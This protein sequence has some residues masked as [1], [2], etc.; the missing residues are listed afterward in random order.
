MKLSDWSNYQPI[1]LPQDCAALLA[2]G[3]TGAIVGLQ[4]SAS[5]FAQTAALRTGG[6]VVEDCYIEDTPNPVIPSGMLRG[7]V[8]VEDGS[9]F[10]DE[11]SVRAQLD[12]LTSNGLEAGIYS[13]RYM[14]DKYHLDDTFSS[15]PLWLSDYQDQYAYALPAG[16]SMVQYSGSGVIPGLS[17]QIDLNYRPDAPQEADVALEIRT[18]DQGESIAAINAAGASLGSALND[19]GVTVVEVTG[20]LPEDVAKYLPAGGHSYLFTT[21]GS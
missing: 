4:Y 2:A 3:F 18:L 9:G 13:S 10:T 16:A 15:L 1:P 8:A 14:L 12:Y 21:K 11:A 7:W 20:G 19:D 6:I 17:Y 5:A